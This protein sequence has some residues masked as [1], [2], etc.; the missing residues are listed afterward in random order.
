MRDCELKGRSMS[1][2][3]T[4][5]VKITQSHVLTSV[6]MYQEMLVLSKAE[7]RG[8]GLLYVMIRMPKFLVKKENAMQSL[9]YSLS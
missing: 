4:V 3:D 2:S 8:Q 5:T 6:C 9:R 7:K 1:A